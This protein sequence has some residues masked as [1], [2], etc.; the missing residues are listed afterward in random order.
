MHN[1]GN[2]HESGMTFW[3][4]QSSWLDSFT[5]LNAARQ[6][7]VAF[8]VVLWVIFPHSILA[9][10]SWESIFW[11]EPKEDDSMKATKWE[12]VKKSSRIGSSEYHFQENRKFLFSWT[13]LI[14]SIRAEMSLKNEWVGW[15]VGGTAYSEAKVCPCESGWKSWRGVCEWL[16]LA[17]LVR[18]PSLN[19]RQLGQLRFKNKTLCEKIISSVN[20]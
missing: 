14:S 11:K 5:C 15:L 9:S 4:I 17:Q 3:S 7:P 2:F 1:G 8:K 18:P 12:V 13:V 6:F 16:D 20:S 10:M 19:F